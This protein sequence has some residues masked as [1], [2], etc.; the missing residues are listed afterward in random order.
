MARTWSAPFRPPSKLYNTNRP[1]TQMSQD[2]EVQGQALQRNRPATACE[3][4]N[5]TFQVNTNRKSQQYLVHSIQDHP[6]GFDQTLMAD[7]P[8]TSGQDVQHQ[9]PTRQKPVRPQ[10]RINSA[11]PTNSVS[12]AVPRKSPAVDGTGFNQDAEVALC[13]TNYCPP[14]QDPISRPLNRPLSAKQLYQIHQS[15][16]LAK[17]KWREQPFEQ[18]VRRL[19]RLYHNCQPS[20]DHLFQNWHFVYDSQP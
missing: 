13:Q 3:P 2:F 4:R 18:Q 14:T 1:Q 6:L 7:Q 16:V 15:D 9:V 10:L 8:N 12:P 17:P 20:R 19:N 5:R 11:A